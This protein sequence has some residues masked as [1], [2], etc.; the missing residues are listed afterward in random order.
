VLD[1]EY[2]VIQTPKYFS[3]TIPIIKNNPPAIAKTIT[4]LNGHC[5][6]LGTQYLIILRVFWGHN[7]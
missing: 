5:G 1:C 3:S 2:S 6:I 4:A 7:T